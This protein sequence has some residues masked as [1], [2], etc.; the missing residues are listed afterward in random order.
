MYEYDSELEQAIEK[1]LRDILIDIMDEARKDIE[2][3]KPNPLFLIESLSAE[4][5]NYL[6]NHPEESDEFY[7]LLFNSSI[8]III[9]QLNNNICDKTTLDLCLDTP[10]CKDYLSKHLGMQY[11][12][13]TI[14]ELIAK[15]EQELADRDVTQ[16]KES[17]S[18]AKQIIKKSTNSLFEKVSLKTKKTLATK[19]TVQSLYNLWKKENPLKFNNLICFQSD[20]IRK[21]KEKYVQFS[22]NPYFIDELLLRLSP[23][24]EDI[25]K[26]AVLP[27]YF[28]YK[29]P[30]NQQFWTKSMRRINNYWEKKKELKK[31][32]T[33]ADYLNSVVF[34]DL[35]QL[36]TEQTNKM[37]ADI[38]RIGSIAENFHSRNKLYRFCKKIIKE[39]N[40]IDYP[41]HEVKEAKVFD[42]FIIELKKLL[43]TYNGK[44]D[45][46]KLGLGGLPYEKSQLSKNLTL[47]WEIYSFNILP[48]C[49]H[50]EDVIKK[51]EDDVL[52]PFH[53]QL[54]KS[55]IPQIK[56]MKFE[57]QRY[58]IAAK[59]MGIV[60]ELESTPQRKNSDLIFDKISFHSAYFEITHNFP[61][62][63]KEK[64]KYNTTI[65]KEVDSFIKTLNNFLKEK[66]ETN[67]SNAIVSST[68]LKPHKSNK[69]YTQSPTNQLSFFKELKT[70]NTDER[71]QPYIGTHKSIM[72]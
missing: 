15:K 33:L 71:L 42:Y 10:G 4:I 11:N 21:N 46:V 57:C 2:Q 55:L 38:S 35:S 6:Q 68:S 49:H 36:T 45:K 69:T 40:I 5:I 47:L 39:K 32:I 62:F 53:K 52:S 8:Q 1:L 20:Q 60:P 43:D 27:L 30:H 23:L 56:E 18:S 59:N 28:S 66:N 48:L 29:D 72:N 58:Q 34:S 51:K 13:D 3:N 70:K 22:I 7:L 31:Y 65:N 19:E 61:N 16:K 17:P 50:I 63:R 41:L 37:L 25:Q 24:T 26:I 64:K 67:P 54:Y 44:K 9:K 14:K 12:I